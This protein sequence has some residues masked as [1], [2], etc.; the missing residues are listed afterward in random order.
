MRINREYL[1][2]YSVK[3]VVKQTGVG[4]LPR[5]IHKT[6]DLREWITL[7]SVA[8]P[9]VPVNRDGHWRLIS[10]VAVPTK[11]EDGSQGWI[12][13]WAAV[14]WSWPEKVAVQK[15][16]FRSR[17]DTASLRQNKK[18]SAHPADT[19]I[20][21]D[22]IART[23]RENAL[24]AVLDRLVVTSPNDKVD[25][26]FLAPHYAGLLPLE[27]YLYYWALIPESREWLRPDVAAC[28]QVSPKINGDA[29]ASITHSKDDSYGTDILPARK[30]PDITSWQQ[31]LD[32]TPQIGPWLQKSLTLAESIPVTQGGLRE[33]LVAELQAVERRWH[34]PGFRVA[35]VGEFNRGKSTLINRLL[36]RFVVPV[37]N[38]STT[39]VVTSM[40]AGEQDQMI[41]RFAKKHSEVRPLEELSWSDL[42][43]IDAAGN[44]REVFAGVQVTLNDTWL[45]S[46]DIELID[47]PGTGDLNGQRGAVVNDV[48]SQCDAVVM[49]VTAISPFGMREATLLKEQVM[50]RHIDRILVV[51]SHLDTIDRAQRARLLHHIQERAIAISETIPVLPLHPID[52][53]PEDVVLDAVRHQIATMVSGSR[54]AWRSQQV[55][56]QLASYLSN[57]VKIGEDAIATA[58]L[59]PIAREQAL[60]QAQ[61]EARASELHWQK[62][63]RE[64]DKRREQCYK[65]LQEK[66]LNAK[67]ELIDLLTFD[68]SRTQN[69]KFWWERELPFRLRRELP[70]IGRKSEDLLMSAIAR[71]FEC[72][73][74]EVSHAFNIQMTWKA[75]ESTPTQ[76]LEI[77]PQELE[78]SDLQQ[79]RLMAR[80]G[81]S[82]AMVGGYVF[83]G[84]IGVITNLG[85]AIL[86]ENF[87]N[88]T[89]EEQ[90]QLITAQFT[91]IVDRAFDEHCQRVSE[92]LR[93][94]YD[95]LIADTKH[96]QSIWKS[97]KNTT[98]AESTFVSI[99]ETA[100]Q[101][102]IA[103]ASALKTEM[104]TAL[105]QSPA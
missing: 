13:P 48:L 36:R 104:S 16:D 66:I 94:L 52:D 60:K 24:F 78:L 12:A 63:R 68:I 39:A 34:L 18:I 10:V 75:V 98:V 95:Q 28:Q 100:W 21:L 80:I 86:G 32:L 40:M 84:P 8:F 41:V 29:I 11:L 53:S 70:A 22:S 73:Q 45:R 76:S 65:K 89:L 14:E 79:Y 97:A 93:H 25:L 62:I 57:L 102:V 42:L 85:I 72:L 88:K 43:A 38:L 33:N 69:P 23:Q 27:V 91:T 82:V 56:G 59:D 71:D 4:A 6:P 15:I 105:Q 103:S 1:K 99:N 3:P 87:L 58:R 26:A 37:G 54:R 30:L 35:V 46:L 5:G 50:G 81:S 44:E 19:N 90:R 9:P 61:E 74:K 7:E 77:K 17:Q 55:A 47:T 64:L 92:R 67:D 83:G 51:V 49:V 101:Q 96:Q 2:Q 31:P 20:T